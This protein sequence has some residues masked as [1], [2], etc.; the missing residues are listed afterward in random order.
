M[1]GGSPLPRSARVLQAGSDALHCEHQG[2]VQLL[3]RCTRRSGLARLLQAAHLHDVQRGDVH[4][5][6]VT[7]LLKPGASTLAKESTA[8]RVVRKFAPSSA[9]KAFNSSEAAR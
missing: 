4:I 1:H 9:L 2:V 8:A 6:R 3:L 5:S 7:L